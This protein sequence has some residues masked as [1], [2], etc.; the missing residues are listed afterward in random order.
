MT[1]D[2][3]TV[4]AFVLVADLK[5]F[6]RAAEALNATQSTVSLKL[7]RL[8]AAL[9]RRLIDRTTRIV[10]LSSDGNAFLDAARNLLEAHQAAV[11]SFAVKR[12]RLTVGISHNIVGA[13]LSIL[14][15]KISSFDDR[16]IIDIRL[17]TSRLLLAEFDR[18][19]IDAAVVLRDGNH[20]QDGEVII[21]EQFGWMGTPAFQHRPAAPLCLA[22]QPAACS[23]R[24]M[25]VATLDG[26]GIAWTESFVGNG[27]AT[28]G[29]AIMTGR[30]IAPLGR[31][32]APTGTIDLGPMIGL[33][34]LPSRDVVL[35]CR[36]S[37]RRSRSLWR[38]LGD[39]IRSTAVTGSGPAKDVA[40]A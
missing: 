5:S 20:R 39:A 23:I 13:E 16:Q 22:I 19:A 10:C 11:A 2:I 3:E 38:I 25:A 28:I 29:P 34:D 17:S 18:G 21:Q 14:L 31:R 26:A 24:Q 27:I 15:E 33:P 1:L 6:T 7:K 37:D 8:E 12:R 35:Y 9:G 4:R 30:T 36:G 40:A 32:V